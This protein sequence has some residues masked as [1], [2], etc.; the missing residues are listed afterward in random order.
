MGNIFS[1]QKLIKILILINIISCISFLSYSQNDTTRYEVYASKYL[2]GTLIEGKVI[3]NDINDGRKIL[4]LAFKEIEKID[5]LYSYQNLNSLLNRINKNPDKEIK[6]D[7]ETY[8]LLKR[9]K[10]Y[11]ALYN[12]LFDITIGKLV[13]LWGFNSEREIRIPDSSL[14]KQYQSFVDYR[15]IILNDQNKTILIRKG[16]NLDLGGIAKGYAIKK[17]CEI[18]NQFGIKDYFIDAGG[19]LYISGLNAEHQTWHI[20]IKHPRKPN[21]FVASFRASNIG[22]ATSGDYE[23]YIEIDGVRYHHIIDP[24]TGFPGNKCQ[25]V[26]VIMDDVEQATAFAK[27]IFL[28]GYEG[29]RKS[30]FSNIPYFI[31][32]ASGKVHY[33]EIFKN[34]YN[35]KIIE[36]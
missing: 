17:A 30:S 8:S 21:S 3:V 22:V 20:G 36:E 7:D 10:H 35:L 34:N 13:D 24:R 27:Y 32:D 2:L 4:Y 12:G 18:I 33:N 25:S 26:T 15:K 14:I 23:R 9:S 31:I 28:L 19:D 1:M 5:S 29:F 11:S 6:L 16:M